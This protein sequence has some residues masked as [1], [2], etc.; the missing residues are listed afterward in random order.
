M[1]HF[2]C[3]TLHRL[4]QSRAEYP[5][6]LSGRVSAMLQAARQLSDCAL[7]APLYIIWLTLAESAFEPR[8]ADGTCAGAGSTDRDGGKAA[9]SSFCRPQLLMQGANCGLFRGQVRAQAT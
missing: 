2:V 9:H 6:L 7:Q 8:R 3:A 4:P 5:S 1:P